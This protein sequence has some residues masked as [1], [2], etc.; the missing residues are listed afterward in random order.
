MQFILPQWLKL[1]LKRYSNYTRISPQEIDILKKNL[2]KYNITNP[3]V[4]IIIPAWNEDE[5]I[6]KT[7]AS[8]ALNK[9]NY[10]CE[11]IIV[12]NNSTDNTQS[13]I[14]EFGVKSFFEEV[15]GIAPARRCGLIN[16]KG[17]YILCCDCDTIY[18]PNW[19]TT[20]VNA[21]IE[22]EK[23]G[24]ACIYGS[25]SFIP[26]NEKLRFLMGLY[27]VF[28]TILKRIKPS[29]IEGLNVMGFNFG[30]IREIGLKSD[31]FIMKNPRKFRNVLGSKD[32]VI[33]SEDAKMA[34]SIVKAGYKLMFVNNKNSVAW[35]S[36]RRLIMEGGFFKGIIIRIIKL[37]S[38][39]LFIKI[40][41]K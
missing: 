2:Q 34:L 26:S 37:I 33:Q 38:W 22:N 36:N 19:I 6:T 24:V 21:L 16:A 5:N 17:K 41:K 13:I 8:L 9:T 39:N 15:Q 12:N 40:K 7:I 27:E 32:F 14:D 1:I 4:S 35:T 10:L 3:L 11:L 29:K 25:Y 28:S 23:S 18:P 30:F 31:G 20:M